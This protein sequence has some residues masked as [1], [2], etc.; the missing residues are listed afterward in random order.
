MR[1]YKRTGLEGRDGNNWGKKSKVK[2]RRKREKKVKGP[3][4]ERRLKGR[5]GTNEEQRI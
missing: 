4:K 5:K 1:G 3:K 2:D